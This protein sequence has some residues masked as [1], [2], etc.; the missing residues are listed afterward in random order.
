MGSNRKETS[1]PVE[2]EY[3]TNSIPYRIIGLYP[4][5]EP[6]PTQQIELIQAA[7]NEHLCNGLEILYLSNSYRANQD[8]LWSSL[9]T[10][11]KHVFTMIT[12]TMECIANNPQF[13][14]ASIDKEGRDAAL[15][16]MERAC[17][18]V[19]AINTAGNHKILAVEI[20]SAPSNS[21]QIQESISAFKH[22]LEEIT[23]WDWSGAIVCIEHCDAAVRWHLP[24]KG[25][26]PLNMELAALSAVCG[27]RVTTPAAMSINWAR[28]AIELRN[29]NLVE[30]QIRQCSINNVLRGMMF[31]GVADEP[32]KF[33][34]AWSDSHCPPNLHRSVDLDE[35][36]SL[37]TGQRIAAAKRAVGPNLLYEGVKI[38]ARPLNA[39][40]GKR[41]ALL[42]RTI[43]LLDNANSE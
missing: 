31:S 27:T 38:S 15:T 12:A 42:R 26:L 7:F 16:M 2:A 36:R 23:S 6:D 29:P 13:G 22:S 5:A 35:P 9:P 17:Q 25:F 41:I 3:K 18:T 10:G 19:K 21:V 4:L 33:G 34:P 37:L 39:P 8:R 14:L 32:T 20:Q 30:N 24:S 11:T 40:I 1:R 43:E 28:S